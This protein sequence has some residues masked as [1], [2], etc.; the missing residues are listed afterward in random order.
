[1]RATVMPCISWTG[2]GGAASLSA[3]G[4][5]LGYTALGVSDLT[6]T[7]EMVVCLTLASS[8]LAAP[9]LDAGT[10]HGPWRGRPQ[11]ADQERP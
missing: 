3:R 4:R 1:M 8:V 10:T 9:L 7:R 6:L 11:A 2:P 5:D